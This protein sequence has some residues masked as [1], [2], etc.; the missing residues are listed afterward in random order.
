MYADCFRVMELHY[1]KKRRKYFFLK[2]TIKRNKKKKEMP[3]RKQQPTRVKQQQL[4]KNF[5]FWFSYVTFFKNTVRF[6]FS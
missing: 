6:G 3:M 5:L 2:K 1:Q 4:R